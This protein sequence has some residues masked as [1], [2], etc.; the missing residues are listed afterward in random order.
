MTPSYVSAVVAG[1]R[2]PSPRIIAAC[3]RLGLPVD[4]LFGD[5]ADPYPKEKQP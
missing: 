1:R 3:A 5:L 4:V 2:P